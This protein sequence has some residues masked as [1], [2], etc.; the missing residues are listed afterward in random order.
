L[1]VSG[2]TSTD[3]EE[4]RQRIDQEY[5]TATFLDEC[6]PPNDVL[7]EAGTESQPED[8]RNDHSSLSEDAISDVGDTDID[9]FVDQMSKEDKN[10]TTPLYSG[11]PISIANAYNRLIRLADALNLDKTKLQTLQSLIKSVF[12]ITVCERQ[13][14]KKTKEATRSDG[15]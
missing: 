10:K 4:I 12:E 6:L 9:D 3:E 5:R 14:G 1:R 2:F 15:S 13:N 8:L 11:R 7:A